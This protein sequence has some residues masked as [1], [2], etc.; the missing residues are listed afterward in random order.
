MLDTSRYMLKMRS[1]GKGELND[2]IFQNC[3]H[4]DQNK[5]YEKLYMHIYTKQLQKL[6][7]FI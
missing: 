2:V 6:M 4:L 5:N 3:G 7:M 1:G